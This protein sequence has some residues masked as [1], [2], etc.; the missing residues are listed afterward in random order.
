M[1]EYTI[2]EA[3]ELLDV[4]TSTVRRRIKSNELKAEKKSSPYGKQYFIPASEI[5]VAAAENEIIELR[6][7]NKNIQVDDLVDK[8]LEESEKK[9]REIV[10]QAAGDVK[11]VITEQSSKIDKQ[12]ETIS[13]LSEKLD[14]IEKRQNK[15]F[16][17]KIKDYFK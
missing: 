15:S 12:Q 9:N 17:D 8:I 13:Q 2:K 16:I 5:D 14:R 10:D 4:S 7:V 3:A 1:E 6:K 11:K